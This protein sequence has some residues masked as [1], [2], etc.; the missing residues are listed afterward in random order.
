MARQN[1]Y[2]SSYIKLMDAYQNFQDG[3]NTKAANETLSEKELPY[4]LNADIAERG[5]IQRRYG[6]QPKRYYD[7]VEVGAKTQGF[8]RYFKADGSINDIV[9]KNGYLYVDGVKKTITGVGQLQTTR[10]MNAVQYK[11]KMYIA[12]GTKLVTFDGTTFSVVTPYA[13]TPLEALY[14]GLNGLAE[15]PETFIQNGVSTVP[16]IQGVKMEEEYYEG[17][18]PKYRHAKYGLVNQLIR[19]TAYYTKAPTDT[20]E[21]KYSWKKETDKDQDWTLDT[22][23]FSTGY[24]GIIQVKV[25]MR[26]VGSEVVIETYIIPKY[27][28]KSTKDATDEGFHSPTINQCNQIFVYWERLYL[29]G[30]PVETDV[31]YGSDVQNFE[32]FPLSNTIRFEN[33]RKEGIST[34]ARYRDSLVVFTNSTI[35]TLLGKAPSSWSRQMV[36]AA[37]GCIAPKSVQAVANTLI[38]LSKDGIYQLKSNTFTE[39]NM[40]VQRIDQGVS[41]MT[42][43]YDVEACSAIHDNQY[44]IVYP[45]I[46]RR[47][48]FY[49]LANAWTMDTSSYMNLSTLFTIDGVLLGQQEN[50][51]TVEFIPGVYTDFAEVYDMEIETKGYSFGEPYHPKKIKEAQIILADQPVAT[52]ASV[53]IFVDDSKVYTGAISIL[54]TTKNADSPKEELTDIYKVKVAGKGHYLKLR[55]KHKE[56]KSITFVGL[57]FIYKTKK[58]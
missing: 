23:M 39:S 18:T 42:A 28:I 55:L 8:F 56:A 52:N 32:Y 41:D 34:I 19:V 9:A 40:N 13:P 5:T 14:V 11:D 10:E 25:E 7:T 47:M 4:I 21:F 29:Y 44:H 22:L 1:M 53:E 15:S 24:E 57:A 49:Y 3:L 26:K 38:F 54:A 12:T 6:M 31:L 33:D 58:P 16:K 48:R 37:V 50:G 27:L 20:L 45:S 2:P 51:T 30:D 46:K 17:T 35:Q 36:N 43:I